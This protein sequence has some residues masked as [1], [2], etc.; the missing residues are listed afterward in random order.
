MKIFKVGFLT[1]FIL[2]AFCYGGTYAMANSDTYSS[3]ITTGAAAI[4]TGGA[5]TTGSAATTTT[6][7]AVTTSGQITATTSA[8]VTTSGQVV[9]Y[10]DV[11][12]EVP[13]YIET[14]QKFTPDVNGKC[15]TNED[16]KY[17]FFE[18]GSLV[19]NRAVLYYNVNTYTDENGLAYEGKENSTIYKYISLVT[20]EK[21]NSY[22]VGINGW[23]R[24]GWCSAYRND[25]ITEYYYCDYDTSI[26]QRNVIVDGYTLGS[27]GQ[28]I[29]SER[30]SD[31][32][33]FVNYHNGEKAKTITPIK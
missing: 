25:G 23:C 26:I 14:K 31:T 15:L 32:Y 6:G 17:H 22:M 10:R 12:K 1:Y 33:R 18:H 13:V 20:D 30:T 16:G 11:V 7:S 5:V 24:K 21:G 3:N 4:T 19:M 9:V 27:D 2:L 8:A 29:E 28:I